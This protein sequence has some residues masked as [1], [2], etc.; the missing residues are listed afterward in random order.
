MK[1]QRT[2]GYLPY[3]AMLFLNAFV[4][5]GHKIVI[6]NTVFKVFDGD[7]QV[8][9]TAIVNALILLPFILMFSPSGFIADR[10]AKP[11]V[12]RFAAW[13]A[14]VL[15]VA[16]TVFYWLGWFWP[17]FAMT[18]L[19]ATQSAIYS[20]AKYGYIKEL[21]GTDRLARGNA[22]VQA[23]TTI[24]ILSGMLVYSAAFEWRLD[25]HPSTSAAEILSHMWPLGLGLVLFSTIEALLARRVPT[26]VAGDAA[27]RFDWAAYGRG[28]MLR[29][30]LA[31]LRQRPMIWWTILGL[32]GFWAISQVL[33]ATFPE[34]AERSL[35]I[36][37]TLVVQGLLATSIIGIM[38][39]S[40]V[41][42]QMSRHHIETGTIPLGALGIA[43][44]LVLTPLLDSAWGHALN[45]ALFGLCGGLF[46]IPLNALM[47]YHA[48]VHEAGRILAGNNFIQNIVMVLFLAATIALSMLGLGSGEIIWV[49][50]AVAVV[51]AWGC[52]RVYPASLLR[53]LLVGLVRRGYRLHTT[54]FDRI[55]R[56]GGV[57]LLGNHISWID[58][59][60]LQAACP[61]PIRFVL[62]RDIYQ[63][64]LM[65]WFFRLF[66]AI[67]ISAD[68]SRDALR[69]VGEALAAGDLV[70]LF[71]EGTISR[72]GHLAEFKRGYEMALKRAGGDC[73]VVP[74]YLHGMWG[75]RLSRARHVSI[76]QRRIRRDLMV[77]FGEPMAADSS[78]RMIKQAV[79]ELAVSCFARVPESVPGLLPL[80][81]RRC[82]QWPRQPVAVPYGGAVLTRRQLWRRAVVLAELLRQQPP[83]GVAVALHGI[84]A[85]IALLGCWLAG[86][87]ALPCAPGV[88]GDLLAT[89]EASLWLGPAELPG[90]AG[91]QPLVLPSPRQRASWWARCQAHWQSAAGEQIALWLQ[92][93]AEY[94]ALT[95][96]ELARQSR[97]IA[98]LLQLAPDAAV[99]T[100]APPLSPLAVRMNLLLPLLE[101]VSAVLAPGRQ[102]P[103]MLARA[104][105]RH[106]VSQLFGDVQVL[107]ELVD[108]ERVTRLHL[109][110]LRQ[111][112]VAGEVSQTLAERWRLRFGGEL[113]AGW[114][115]GRD[116]WLCL[117]LAD[118]L[119]PRYWFV[120]LGHRPGSLGQPLPGVALRVGATALEVAEADDDG[121][122]HWRPT[123]VVGQLDDE[124]FVWPA[125]VAG[126]AS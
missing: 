34:F 19:L 31:G 15:C 47:Q 113:L 107:Q 118:V 50:A 97:Q 121:V 9:L 75:S 122:L 21:L 7:L 24:A 55:P 91:L 92:Q 71:P 96:A 106:G 11:A 59:V 46:I 83:G 44:G 64:R 6:Q 23:A 93:G 87:A 54:G 29:A 17:A 102:D 1:A 104:I 5:L 124:G 3:V 30:N 103:L 45:F 100:A 25:G 68:R 85:Q 119:D 16:I 117:N 78:N 111:V 125:A 67:P 80:V 56:E 63:H 69:A 12:M 120:Q 36:D 52:V 109:Q 8:V 28:R 108:D 2:L 35:N 66:D 76:G 84:E 4:D 40:L 114:L 74:F 70:C 79:R 123:L 88:S 61:R 14:V 98:D 86:R 77:A 81:R 53:M 99:L 115:D 60:L 95:H 65:H 89:A 39:G 110:P 72:T 33:I 42:G 94:H 32:S 43:I 22:V 49:L 112:V 90:P 37:S 62:E 48:P 13:L 38:L 82:R 51:G 57:L 18:F 20:P 10:F 105:A 26:P 73:V 101:P 41:A 116:G 27:L 126:E 58:W